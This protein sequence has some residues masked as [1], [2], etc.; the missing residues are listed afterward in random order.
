MIVVYVVADD[1]SLIKAKLQNFQ[2]ELTKQYN[3]CVTYG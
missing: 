3:V 1:D 2:T